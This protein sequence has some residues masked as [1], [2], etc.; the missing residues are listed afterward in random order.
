MLDT[1]RAVSAFLAYDHEL[2]FVVQS[3]EKCTSD[4]HGKRP[5]FGLGLSLTGLVN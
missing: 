3:L 2:L 4:T 1:S 5:A